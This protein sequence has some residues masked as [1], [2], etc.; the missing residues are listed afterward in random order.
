MY[1]YCFLLYD[2]FSGFTT[3]SH[4]A[5]L[6][7]DD[8]PN[9]VTNTCCIH[10]LALCPDPLPTVGPIM[11]TAELPVFVSGDNVP[12]ESGNLFTHFRTLV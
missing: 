6:D 12:G 11:P 7:A 1:Y 2:F 9:L 5:L 8:I 3:E 10:C 4:S